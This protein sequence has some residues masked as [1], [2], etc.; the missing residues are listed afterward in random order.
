MIQHEKI[1]I[2]HIKNGRVLNPANN[3]DSV[4][5]I[6]IEKGAIVNR[7]PTG[8]KASDKSTIDAQ[9]CWV[10]P[11]IVDLAARFR[12]PGQEY[13]G[14][15]ASESKAALAGG[16]T[17]VCLQPDTIPVIDTPAVVDLIRQR[18]RQ[19]AGPSIYT[20]GAMSVALQGTQ[21]SEFA[22]LKA[23]GCVGV[24]QAGRYIENSQLM[25]NIMDYA[26]SHN[27]KVFLTPEDSQLAAAGCAHEGKVATRLGLPGIPAAAETIAVARDLMLIEATG[28][29][30]HFCRLSC[31]RSVELINQAKAQGLD[32]SAD[33]AAH[34]LFLTEFDIS[35]YDSNL[36]VRP[37]LR[38]MRD[39]DALREGIK[40]GAIDAICSD[41]QPHDA[42]AKLAPFG[43]TSA[44]IS[45]LDTLATL[46][47]KLIQEDDLAP[48]AATQL[49]THAPA[50]ILGIHSGTLNIG[51]VADIAIIDPQANWTFAAADSHSNGKNTPFDGWSFAGRVTHTLIGGRLLHQL[52]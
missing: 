49:L 29:S 40:N 3:E 47:L 26:V 28:V 36:H 25:R 2:R 14:T 32:V 10:I 5:D 13:K 45:A 33:V 8:G 31:S 11:G 38:S 6:F 52:T 50:N 16:I 21:L 9:G 15:F 17:S 20:L 18:T 46:L 22:A 27:L 39:K 19:I 44:G 48:L 1:E 12:E 30:A 35:H 43:E 42:D 23:A 51:A 37:P 4:R 34:Q 24:S 41:H 7:L